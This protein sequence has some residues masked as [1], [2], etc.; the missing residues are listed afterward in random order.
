MALTSPKQYQVTLTGGAGVYTDIPATQLAHFMLLWEDGNRSAV[1]NY[2]LPNDGFTTVYTTKAG[3]P[4][5]LYG[6]GRY[7]ALG[8]PADMSP[9]NGETVADVVIQIAESGG[10]A[11]V[12]NVL[13]SASE[14][15]HQAV[16]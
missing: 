14:V 15:D 11:S 6:D 7:G 2:K 3:D 9:S 4:I 8:R 16:F 5:K 13:E 10:A 1:F 12:L